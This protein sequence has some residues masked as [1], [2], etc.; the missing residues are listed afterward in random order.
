MMYNFPLTSMKRNACF[1]LSPLPSRWLGDASE[2][3]AKGSHV[4][5][6]NNPLALNC[7]CNLEYKHGREG[8][9]VVAQWKQI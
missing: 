3:T 1:S 4:L 9:L 8:V 5:R 6:Q 2:W 7:P